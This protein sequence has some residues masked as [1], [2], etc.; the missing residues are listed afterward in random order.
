M[1]GK[2]ISKSRG[3][4]ICS[5]ALPFSS[6]NWTGSSCRKAQVDIRYFLDNNLTYLLKWHLS[7]LQLLSDRC[8]AYY[9]Q[10]IA[11]LPIVLPLVYS[12]TCQKKMRFHQQQ[13]GS[14]TADG[15]RQWWEEGWE[16]CTVTL[17]MFLDYIFCHHS[18]LAR[19]GKTVES[20]MANFFNLLQ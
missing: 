19:G 15:H 17:W 11:G 1:W 7:G 10:P 18:P 16:I 4:V 3:T 14:W 2:V 6:H 12:C 9:W 8:I 20:E 13:T 5:L